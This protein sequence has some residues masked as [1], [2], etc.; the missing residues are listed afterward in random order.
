M[1]RILSVA[2]R[3]SGRLSS[4]ATV[5]PPPT[6]GAEAPS[7]ALHAGT[8]LQEHAARLLGWP[9]DPFAARHEDFARKL[10]DE[11]C[12]CLHEYVAATFCLVSS[13]ST[14]LFFRVPRWRFVW[15]TSD[16]RSALGAAVKHYSMQL[17]FRRDAGDSTHVTSAA[18]LDKYVEAYD[19]Q[20]LVEH[21][22]NATAGASS[23]GN[24]YT[25]AG[26]AVYRSGARSAAAAVLQLHRLLKHRNHLTLATLGDGAR[27]PVKCIMS[28]LV[29]KAG[30]L[31][32]A[33]A[34][35]ESSTGA[36][37]AVAMRLDAA[38]RHSKGVRRL[39]EL[40][41][42]RLVPGPMS[43]NDCERLLG[44]MASPPVDIAVAAAAAFVLAP[45]FQRV[46]SG[47]FCDASGT[48]GAAAGS[49]VSR[50]ALGAVEADIVRHGITHKRVDLTGV[51]LP[52]VLNRAFDLFVLVTRSTLS[53]GGSQPG[54]DGCDAFRVAN[55][56]AGGRGGALLDKVTLMP[57]VEGGPYRLFSASRTMRA[58]ETAASDAR[59][60]RKADAA[61]A[62]DSAAVTVQ[63]LKTAVDTWSA[64]VAVRAAAD[65][66]ATVSDDSDVDQLGLAGDEWDIIIA[67]NADR[68]T[69]MLP[70]VDGRHRAMFASDPPPTTTLP[71]SSPY[72]NDPFFLL[73]ALERTFTNLAEAGGGAAAAVR[74]RDQRD[75]ATRLAQLGRLR[76]LL[77][78]H[79]TLQKGD[80]KSLT[81]NAVMLALVDMNFVITHLDS[82]VLPDDGT[83]GS[84][85]LVAPGSDGAGDPALFRAAIA[86]RELWREF[87]D[88]YAVAPGASARRTAWEEYRSALR[89]AKEARESDVRTIAGPHSVALARWLLASVQS[90]SL[91]R[92]SPEWRLVTTKLAGLQPPAAPRAPAAATASLAPYHNSWA[93][94]SSDDE[95]SD[96]GE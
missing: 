34:L 28:A 70:S 41:K 96:A 52:D 90:G 29:D 55:E 33:L 56:L 27:P 93:A 13:A 30:N 57:C 84:V 78:H 10:L 86:A 36:D 7:P 87:Y 59:R 9:L 51:T 37:A 23:S 18:D 31:L 2:E 63:A 81:A 17:P 47:A 35:L 91:P 14:K 83:G 24:T 82:T 12:L 72:Y 43:S 22:M 11:L 77:A 64:S 6:G 61:A 5:A 3:L 26:R 8:R 58:V 42:A 60:T 88:T 92:D 20:N 39:C 16:D 38:I 48:G 79:A 49:G 85:A 53:Y 1:S 69:P 65:A 25:I 66:P 46:P 40:W 19:L 89:A 75:M 32:A 62:T 73:H 74:R 45:R 95:G 67:D 44:A 4:R 50:A 68:V 21:I 71:P 76:D 80:G 15:A 94:F 54:A